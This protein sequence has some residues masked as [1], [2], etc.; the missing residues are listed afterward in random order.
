[1]YDGDCVGCGWLYIVFWY[2]WWY[3]KGGCI[4]YCLVDLFKYLWDDCVFGLKYWF[5]RVY[6][7]K[8]NYWGYCLN[9]LK[10]FV[11]CIGICNIGVGCSCII[12]WFWLGFDCL[13]VYG[14][15]RFWFGKI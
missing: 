12:C 14:D 13:I 2:F 10:R 5:G 11:G 6:G 1:M 15:Y 4:C 3:C 8:C 9:K 7:V